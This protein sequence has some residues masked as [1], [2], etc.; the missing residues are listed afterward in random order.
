MAD[1]A[2]VN[3]SGSNF[4]SITAPTVQLESSVPVKANYSFTYIC[5]IISNIS[6]FYTA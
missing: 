1:K 2:S 4:F 3:G 5:A 6:F